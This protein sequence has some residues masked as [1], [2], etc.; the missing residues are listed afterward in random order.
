MTP[1]QADEFAI[2]IAS[3]DRVERIKIAIDKILDTR[4]TLAKLAVDASPYGGRL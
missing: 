4:R 3:P 2:A 1:T